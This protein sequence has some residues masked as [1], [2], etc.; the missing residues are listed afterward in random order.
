[1]DALSQL[2][3]REYAWLTWGW[4]D[5]W[6]DMPLQKY[7]CLQWGAN[8]NRPAL[9]SDGRSQ[10]HRDHNQDPATHPPIL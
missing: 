4:L 10:L 7:D 5:C 6:R 2:K 8:A 3:K 9:H 1:M